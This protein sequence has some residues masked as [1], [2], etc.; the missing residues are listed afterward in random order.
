MSNDI[1]SHVAYQ[2]IECYALLY[3]DITIKMWPK[4][5]KKMRDLKQ[6]RKHNH[7][8]FENIT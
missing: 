7:D 2:I 4:L 5:R 1:S 8:N 3:L 6:L